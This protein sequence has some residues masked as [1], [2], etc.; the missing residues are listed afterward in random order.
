MPL[1]VVSL[2]PN[3]F[4]T[5]NLRILSI[6]T[7]GVDDATMAVTVCAGKGLNCTL[8]V[9]VIVLPPTLARI[10]DVPTVIGAVKIAV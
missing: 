5:V 8:A 7:V 1:N 4:F 2:L 6:P 10:V 9:A 3:A